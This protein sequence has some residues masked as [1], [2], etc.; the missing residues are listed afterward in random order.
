MEEDRVTAVLYRPASE[1][2]SKVPAAVIVNSSGGVSAHTDHYYARVLAGQG[3]AAL[4][5]DSFTSRGVRRTGD[6]QNRVPQVKSNA[7]AFAGHRWLSMQSWVD[8]TRIVVM[9]MSRG[10]EAAYSAALEVLRQRM[11]VVDKAFAA[12]VALSPG[13]CNFPQRDARTI[14]RPIFFM[15]AELDQT[16]LV[17]SCIEYAERMRMAGKATI[18]IAVY[19]GVYHTFESTGG[20][21]FAAADW[22]ST[23]CAGRFERDE[24]FVLYERR[25]RRRATAGSQTEY[26]FRTCL[27]RGYVLGG[28]ERVKAQA[29]ADLLQFF[30]DSG[31]LHDEAARAIVPDCATL[32]EGVLRLN[33]TR[34]RA[35]W[36]GDLVALARAYNRGTAGSRDDAL[37][38]RLL[39]LAVAR[40]HVQ[41]RWE[42]ALLLRQG[43]GVPRDLPRALSLAK[44]AAEA[45]DDVGMN[46]LGVM[47]RDGVGRSRDDAEARSW[48]ERS[49]ELLN[50]YGMVN[51]GRFYKEGRGGLAQNA[52]QAATLWRRAANRDDNPSAQLLLAVALETGDGVPEDLAEARRLY[53]AAAEQNREPEIKRLAVEAMKRLARK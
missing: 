20:V 1:S 11:G 22:A 39:E 46:V 27:K 4:I 16:Q 9:G 41:A 3:M 2:E 14:D 19:P 40:G 52:G 13:S 18:R 8:P 50:T 25:S 49:A 44:D 33:C 42:L 21:G 31:V 12:H 32:P 43:V 29:T 34:A 6:D 36:I 38:V 45:G 7:D 48:F 35:G 37:A 5:V 17:R 53:A 26:L 47:I 15:L 28:D 30:R 23:E 10:G 51:L 24:H